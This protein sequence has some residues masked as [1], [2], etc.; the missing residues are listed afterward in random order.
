FTVSGTGIVNNSNVLQN[1]VNQSDSAGNA[2]LLRFV[3][4]ATA[5]DLVS[6]LN[7]G[8]VHLHGAVIQFEDNS[9]AGTAQFIQLGANAS[10]TE[11]GLITFTGTS[12]AANGTFV[13]TADEQHSGAARIEFHDATTAANGTFTNEKNGI[14][15]LGGEV[16]FYDNTTADHAVFTNKAAFDSGVLFHDNSSAGHAT[17]VNEGGSVYTLSGFTYFYDTST[18][19][20]GL[21]IANGSFTDYYG[22]STVHFFTD[23]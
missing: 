23:A 13:N 2:G 8:L 17:I 22:N 16:A 4:N 21:F 19:G 14:Y 20:N 10:N 15:G 11:V 5:G 7:Q 6:Y 9:N 12:S 18:A 3:G 1:F